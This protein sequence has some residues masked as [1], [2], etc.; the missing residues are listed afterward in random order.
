MKEQG[1]FFYLCDKYEYSFEV[2]KKKDG[3]AQIV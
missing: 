2:L 3:E 1:M